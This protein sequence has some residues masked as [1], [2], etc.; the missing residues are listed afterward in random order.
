[1]RVRLEYGTYLQAVFAF[2]HQTLNFFLRRYFGQ[3]VGWLMETGV[4]R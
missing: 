1:M 3:G 2:S 4:G